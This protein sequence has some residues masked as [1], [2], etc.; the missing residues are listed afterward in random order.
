[1]QYQLQGRYSDCG[2]AQYPI[3]FAVKIGDGSE[4]ALNLVAHLFFAL[5]V[6]LLVII[7]AVVKALREL[8]MDWAA[9]L[10]AGHHHHHMIATPVTK[11]ESHKINFCL[12]S[13]I[14]LAQPLSVPCASGS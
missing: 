9:I 10:R 7:P 6:G 4:Y 5:P 14:I 12:G 3:Q 1:V 11:P 8:S 13:I 2:P